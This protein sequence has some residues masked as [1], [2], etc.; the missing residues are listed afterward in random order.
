M[1]SRLDQVR[2]WPALAKTAK[3]Q[4]KALARI[5]KVSERQL[6]RYLWERFQKA[7]KH[8]LD[9]WRAEVA[10]QDLDRGE[11]VKAASN[12]ACFSSSSNFNRFYKRVTGITPRNRT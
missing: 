2:D 3:Y 1:K 11:L 8:L 10:R 4:L 12:S 5:S 6:R 7:P 9:A